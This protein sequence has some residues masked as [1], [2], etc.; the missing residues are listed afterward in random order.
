MRVSKIVSAAAI[1]A[2]SLGLV[3][4][5]AASAAPVP[6]SRSHPA[7]FS[8]N[9]NGT[10]TAYRHGAPRLFIAHG[11]S[12]WVNHPHF[13]VWNSR[14]AVVTGTVW[15]ADSGT[16]RCGTALVFTHVGGRMGY[17]LFTSVHIKRSHGVEA[18]W[19]LRHSATWIGGR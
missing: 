11:P 5:T 3:G 17:Y 12:I 9:R 14:E 1:A 15:C 8:A 16:W 19:N 7:V 2:A 4:T 10:A 18:N 6:H 13:T